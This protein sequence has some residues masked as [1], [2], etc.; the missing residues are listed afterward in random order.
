VTGALEFTSTGEYREER[1]YILESV[2]RQENK[3]DAT[4]QEVAVVKNENVKFR[5][6]L[7]EAHGRVRG[8]IKSKDDLNRRLMGMEM[9]AG[10]IA[11]LAGV[12]T[13]GAIEA[14]RYFLR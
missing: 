6:D 5:A 8:L 10:T 12:L 7:N 4:L 3:L 13:A 14:L 2:K 9:K 1:L 11:S